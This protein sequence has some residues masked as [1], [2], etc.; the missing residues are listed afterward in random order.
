MQAFRRIPLSVGAIYSKSG[1]IL[2]SE[3][4]YEGKKYPIEKIISRRKRS[5]QVVPCIAPIEYTVLIDSYEKKIYFE[6]DTGKWF[7]VMKVTIPQK[8]SDDEGQSDITQ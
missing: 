6:K 1:V 5:P 7:S 4:I 3:V 8:V 2:P